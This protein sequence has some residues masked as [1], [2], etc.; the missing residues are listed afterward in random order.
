M[1][2]TDTTREIGTIGFFVARDDGLRL[3]RDLLTYPQAVAVATRMATAFKRQYTIASGRYVGRGQ[4]R[5]IKPL[6]WP[7]FPRCDDG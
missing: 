5:T 7:I 2:T 1:P 4:Q 3:N 6:Q